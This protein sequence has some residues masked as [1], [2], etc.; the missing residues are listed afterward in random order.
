M[1][2]LET[3][4]L[5]EKGNPGFF[6]ITVFTDRYFWVDYSRIFTRMKKL[7]LVIICSIVVRAT[8]IVL[9]CSAVQCEIYDNVWN[10][11]SDKIKHC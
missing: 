10:E 9:P 4:Q 3:C 1:C 7:F 2:H 11:I 8:G 5:I 6:M